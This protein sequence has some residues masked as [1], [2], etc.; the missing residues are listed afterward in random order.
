M[1]G[2]T[3]GAGGAGADDLAGD[4]TLWAKVDK[5]YGSTSAYPISWVTS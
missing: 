3:E 1:G 4:D 2:E 5:V